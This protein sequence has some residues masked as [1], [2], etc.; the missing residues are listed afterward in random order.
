MVW[1]PR[2]LDS[3]P[4]DSLVGE[5]RVTIPN[6]TTYNQH[7]ILSVNKTHQLD[8]AVK[9]KHDKSFET[10]VDELGR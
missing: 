3:W 2:G 8:P 7:N 9:T 5:R 4:D 6:D 10:S 1:C